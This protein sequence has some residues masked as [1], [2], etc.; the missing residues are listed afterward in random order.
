M[1][2]FHHPSQCLDD[3]CSLNKLT[4]SLMQNSAF[5]SSISWVALGGRSLSGCAA[6]A[7]T[8]RGNQMFVACVAPC[9]TCARATRCSIGST[10]CCLR[11]RIRNC[12][13]QWGE[14]ALPN[15]PRTEIQ[16]GVVPVVRCSVFSDRKTIVSVCWPHKSSSTH[17]RV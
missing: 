1:C 5:V 13:H 9:L 8:Q 7:G 15:I 12:V 4:R 3:I 2:F 10:C 11:I 6:F 16:S 17:H 14:T